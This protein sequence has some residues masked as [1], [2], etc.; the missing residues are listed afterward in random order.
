MLTYSNTNC[1]P[2]MLLLASGHEGK[3]VVIES[4][5]YENFELSYFVSQFYI[6]REKDSECR[7]LESEGFNFISRI[8]NIRDIKSI[9]HA[10]VIFRRF[11]NTVIFHETGLNKESSI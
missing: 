11:R 8:F 3:M 6:I 5:V 9:I 1:I 4:I 10:K 2:K 7:S